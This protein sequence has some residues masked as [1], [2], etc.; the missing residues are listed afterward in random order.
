MVKLN[1]ICNM[2][3]GHS[4]WTKSKSEDSIEKVNCQKNIQGNDSHEGQLEIVDMQ[5]EDLS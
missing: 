1:G 5:N 3:A 2:L 4:S